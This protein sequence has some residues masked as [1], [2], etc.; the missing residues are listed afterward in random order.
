MKSLQPGT[1]ADLR[2]GTRLGGERIVPRCTACTPQRPHRIDST[3]RHNEA[4]AFGGERSYRGTIYTQP[5]RRLGMV[6]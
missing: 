4:C 6:A 2:T 3:T 5:T 1:Y